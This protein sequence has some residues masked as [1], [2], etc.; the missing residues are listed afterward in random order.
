MSEQIGS[1]EIAVDEVSST[2]LPSV[3]E[4]LAAARQARGLDVLDIAQALKLGPR[5]VE[6]LEN[7]DWQGLPGQTF[8]RGFVRNY[9]RLVQIDPAPLMMQLDGVL[10]KPVSSLSVPETRPTSMPLTGGSA[11]RRDRAVMLT[12]AGWYC[13][14]PWFISFCPTT[15][16]LGATIRRVCSTRWPARK[17][18]LPRRQMPLRHRPTRYFRRAR[19]RSRS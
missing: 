15:F 12:G 17:C 5:Q 6:A 14:P 16:R 4:Q 7:G 11:S 18:R 10:E 9:A 3:G 19:H 1:D 13:L 2:S 8:V